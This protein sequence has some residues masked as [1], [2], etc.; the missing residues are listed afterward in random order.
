MLIP[1][2]Y[3]FATKY[4]SFSE[5]AINEISLMTKHGNLTLTAQRNLLRARFPEIHFQDQDLANVIQKYKNV[6][7][8]DNDA[9][10]LLTMLMKKKAEDLRW[11]VD[12]E[13]D[14]DNHL[15]RLL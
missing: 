7:K 1:K 2:T 11:V 9:S 8:I 15:T 10:V 13:L 12:F 4:Q 5:E 6:N 14:N 3:E